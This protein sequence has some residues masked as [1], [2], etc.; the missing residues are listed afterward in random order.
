MSE[1]TTHNH[2]DL[3]AKIARLVEEKGWNQEDFAK[4]TRLNRQTIRQIL[5]LT[6]DRRLRNAT[7]HACA[8]ALNLTVH[9]L[10]TLPVE[11]LLQRVRQPPPPANGDDRLNCLYRGASQP[12]LV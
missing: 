2:A 8:E 6:G 7:I 5:Q 4:F 9:E 3:A 12:E 11:R 10:R 1:Q